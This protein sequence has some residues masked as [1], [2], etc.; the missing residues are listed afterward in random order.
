MT[1]IDP[2]HIRY[3]IDLL[4]EIKEKAS[5]DHPTW[6]W[7]S[8]DGILVSEFAERYS[9]YNSQMDIVTVLLLSEWDKFSGNKWF[10][11]PA[12]A[13]SELDPEKC[14][15]IAASY[16]DDSEYGK[17]NFESV[18]FL[19]NKLESIL[20]QKIPVTRLL[21]DDYVVIVGDIRYG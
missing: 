6:G 1:T 9:I 4:K 8:I 2:L 13:G 19:I 7:K 18:D 16:W 10:P 11:V 3:T 15:Q 12:G 20:E 21:T 5:P 14:F 17:L